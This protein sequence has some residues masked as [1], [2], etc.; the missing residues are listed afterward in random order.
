MTINLDVDGKA[1]GVSSKSPSRVVTPGVLSLILLMAFV[2]W[3]DSRKM[4]SNSPLPQSVSCKTPDLVVPGEV[5]RYY[6]PSASEKWWMSN[7]DTVQAVVCHVM[8]SAEHIATVQRILDVIVAQEIPGPPGGP[9]MAEFVES[10]NGADKAGLLSHMVYEYGDGRVERVAMEP[11]IG[12]LRDP[13][14]SCPQHGSMFRPT[15]EDGLTQ[16]DLVELKPWVILDPAIATVAQVFTPKLHAGLRQAPYRRALLFDMGGSRWNDVAGSR[17]IT[18][19]LAGMGLSFEHI[20][21]WEMK[22]TIQ[23]GYF[24]GAGA[25]MLSRMHFFNWPVTGT[26][27]DTDNP[28]TILKTVATKEDFV[29][30]KLDIDFPAVEMPLVQQLLNDPELSSLVDEFSFEHHVNVPDMARWWGTDLPGNLRSSYSIFR[31]IREKGI[32]AHS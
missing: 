19:K 21:V 20:Y 25:E 13:R 15:L 1:K 4:S 16:H 32:H 3:Y 24:E 11:L 31:Q 18:T 27:G 5:R 30:V 22:L 10:L 23:K 28:F 26:V 2:A 17:W 29:V 6:E 9:P 8:A 7:V 14:T 12:M